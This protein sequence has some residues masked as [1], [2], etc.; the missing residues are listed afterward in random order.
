MSRVIDA[1]RKQY[2]AYAE[3]SDEDL[4]I[5]IGKKYPVYL[6]QDED[7]KTAYD[8]YTGVTPT[9]PPTLAPP[10]P[11]VSE[12]AAADLL[13]GAQQRGETLALDDDVLADLMPETRAFTPTSGMERAAQDFQ[14]TQDVA[15]ALQDLPEA[16]PEQKRTQKRY[17]LEQ[18]AQDLAVSGRY[19]EGKPLPDD[20]APKPFI[21]GNWLDQVGI[22]SKEIMPTIGGGAY[23][24]LE[25]MTTPTRIPGTDTSVRPASVP[26]NL[27][28]GIGN[29]LNAAKAVPKLRGFIDKQINKGL[30]FIRD[31]AEYAG[32]KKWKDVEAVQK[33]VMAT[34]GA[35]LPGEAVKTAAV[36]APAVMAGQPAG[37]IGMAAMAGM[38]QIGS[39]F[40]DT[41]KEWERTLGDAP[42]NKEEAKSLAVQQTMLT[43]TIVGLTTY[44]FGPTGREAFGKSLVGDLLEQATVKGIN[45]QQV[46]AQVTRISGNMA[47]EMGWEIPEEVLQ[48]LS[49]DL[50]AMGTSNPDMTWNELLENALKA[51][52]LAPTSAAV[53]VAPTAVT[54]TGAAIVGEPARKRAL[55]Q[56]R[57]EIVRGG[58]PIEEGERMV[59]GEKVQFD[60]PAQPAPPDFTDPFG[61]AEGLP[62]TEAELLAQQIAQTGQPVQPAAQPPAQPEPAGPAGEAEDEQKLQADGKSMAEKLGLKFRG[63]GGMPG[64]KKPQLLQFE[65]EDGDSVNIP[66]GTSLEEARKKVEAAQTE[67]AARKGKLGLYERLSPE[68]TAMVVQNEGVQDALNEIERRILEGRVTDKELKPIVADIYNQF[69]DLPTEFEAY[70]E[71]AAAGMSQLEIAAEIQENKRLNKVRAEIRKAARLRV[72]EVLADKEA[73]AKGPEPAAPEPTEA[74]KKAPGATEKLTPAIRFKFRGTTRYIVA[75]THA[76]AIALGVKTYGNDFVADMPDEGGYGFLQQG[77]WKTRSEAGEIIGAQRGTDAVPYLTSENL[78]AEELAHIKEA[79]QYGGPAVPEG[80]AAAPEAAAPEAGAPEAAWPRVKAVK[81]ADK[82][83]VR[84][85]WFVVADDKGAVKVYD[86]IGPQ[87][88]K[89]VTL[90]KSDPD[91]SG[92]PAGG[93]TYEEALQAKAKQA[94]AKPEMTVPQ[95]KAQ[96]R[97]I[98]AALGLQFDEASARTEPLV[99]RLPDGSYYVKLYDPVTGSDFSFRSGSSAEEVESQLD[100]DRT[101]MGRTGPHLA[102]DGRPFNVV[103]T[104]KGTWTRKYVEDTGEEVVSGLESL[105][106]R[107]PKTGDPFK[108]EVFHGSGRANAK[109]VYAG[110]EQIPVAGPATYYALNKRDAEE[111]GP[112]VEKE[113]LSLQQPYVVRSGQEWV[114]LTKKAGWQDWMLRGQGAAGRKKQTEALAQYLVGKGYDSLI[115]LWPDNSPYDQGPQGQNYET[116]RKVFTHSQIVVYKKTP[117]EAQREEATERF[118]RRY[119]QLLAKKTLTSKEAGELLGMM[120][121]REKRRY[122]R[123]SKTVN[124]KQFDSPEARA[125]QLT[126]KILAQAVRDLSQSEILYMRVFASLVGAKSNLETPLDV[127]MRGEDGA[128]SPREVYSAFAKTRKLIDEQIGDYI[129]LYRAEGVRTQTTSHWFTT[130]E[131]ALEVSD[132]V[133]QKDVPTKNIIAVNVGLDGTIEDVIVGKVPMV[134]LNPKSIQIAKHKDYRST[135]EWEATYPNKRSVRLIYDEAKSQWFVRQHPRG[136]APNRMGNL[137]PVPIGK[138]MEQARRWLAENPISEQQGLAP[139]ARAS[140]EDYFENEELASLK[141]AMEKFKPYKVPVAKITLT[142][143][144]QEVTLQGRAAERAIAKQYRVLKQM[145]TIK[146][147]LT[148]K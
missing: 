109:Q 88:T 137:D 120:E 80:P 81:Q 65:T 3:V 117:A 96:G 143:N 113:K 94:K 107:N 72:E 132:K 103:E 148:L 85:G 58:R 145:K 128:L 75:P 119:N 134:P 86:V 27:L 112:E 39:S 46:V 102:K 59:A 31:T 24:A 41:V 29:T 70:A 98:A 121:A 21:E 90:T 104:A 111:Y 67:R 23:G 22:Q 78:T 91:F 93:Y 74:Q 44:L 146:K 50:I 129:T 7:F 147:C 20:P 68:A 108:V 127:V 5:A 32:G 83:G 105:L 57:E 97:E 6:E 9:A 47:K 118:S 8:Q 45:R 63:V 79:Q 2:P 141:K 35:K 115:V 116:L 139:P 33:E 26:L 19:L 4:T 62:P 95:R 54:E 10:Q 69:D 16:T 123:R 55:Q 51:G 124:A 52:I 142:I 66:V 25:Q 34:K 106:A 40:Q 133:E 42:G 15:Q 11:D 87:T 82:Y 114:E 60:V 14:S 43:G 140:A 122:A 56:E 135:G 37:I 18:E 76:D 89:Q 64:R 84:S 130:R 73:E 138:D 136:Q 61:R 38:Q 100:Q 12:Q 48:Q 92:L 53:M 30:E 13:S 49:E 99:T 125:S 144:N 101:M 17:G 1:I 131:Q 110:G 28:P 77:Q 126:N 36:S 71:A